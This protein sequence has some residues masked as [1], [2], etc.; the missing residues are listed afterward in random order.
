MYEEEYESFGSG[1]ALIVVIIL[2]ILFATMD[3][4][5]K[6]TT[7]AEQNISISQPLAE[8]Q[9]LLARANAL[10]EA[11]QEVFGEPGFPGNLNT[12]SV[13]TDQQASG[14]NNALRF[15]IYKLETK[16]GLEHTVSEPV[17]SS[18]DT[19][20]RIA[21]ATTPMARYHAL[22]ARANE[23]NILH[24]KAY[25]EPAFKGDLSNVKVTTP[26]QAEG[27]AN[28]LQY[29]IYTIEEKL[30]LEHS[31]EKPKT[32]AADSNRSSGREARVSEVKSEGSVIAN[33]I[34]R[35]KIATLET[36]LALAKETVTQTNALQADSDINLQKAQ[37]RIVELEAVLAQILQ[38]L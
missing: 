12:V 34:L 31:V 23:L 6:S 32:V 19:V 15:V 21:Q 13:T 7:A 27:S 36:E 9:S 29:S 33:G 1:V 30:G 22:V 35:E 3:S 37:T 2:I 25:G 20:R 24:T 10:N 18:T 26:Q 11:H 16:L 38:G 17:Q 8:Y 28:A 5:P 14:A 4:E